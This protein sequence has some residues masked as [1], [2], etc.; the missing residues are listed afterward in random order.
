M[1][2]PIEEE[3]LLIEAKK[4]D[5]SLEGELNGMIPIY[6]WHTPKEDKEFNSVVKSREDA[7]PILGD[8]VKKRTMKPF[9]TGMIHYM[10]N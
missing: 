1:L 2:T 3:E 4:V 6:C 8:L 7:T 10:P 5:E 9:G